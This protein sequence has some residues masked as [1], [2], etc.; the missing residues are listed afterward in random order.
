MRLCHCLALSAFVATLSAEPVSAQQISIQQTVDVMDQQEAIACAMDSD[1]QVLSLQP[2]DM[3]CDLVCYGID[4]CREVPE[5]T[6]DMDCTPDGCTERQ[7]C[8]I[9]LRCGWEE[10]CRTE[11]HF[12]RA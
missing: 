8:R 10:V 9:G 7:S 12:T 3:D 6:T 1:P 5:C 4:V 11:C 2:L